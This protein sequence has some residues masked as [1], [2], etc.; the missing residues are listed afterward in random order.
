MNNVEASSS[1]SRVPRIS[2]ESM[3]RT[4][5]SSEHPGRSG[6]ILL[7]IGKKAVGK[8][9]KPLHF[10]D[11]W[12]KYASKTAKDLLKQKSVDN[13]ANSIHVVNVEAQVQTS[14]LLEISHPKRGE[15]AIQTIQQPPDVNPS[16]TTVHV[17][18][19]APATA[20]SFLRDMAPKLFS[21]F[22]SR[23]GSWHSL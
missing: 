3:R 18:L 21:S 8:C 6:I 19:S 17:S 16:R 11:A 9:E 20:A 22:K 13:E 4:D 2:G 5:S 1:I 12:L 10:K 7:S 14:K 15:T 23:T